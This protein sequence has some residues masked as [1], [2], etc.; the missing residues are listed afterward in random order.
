MAP[1]CAAGNVGTELSFILPESDVSN[2]PELFEQLEKSKEKLG[3]LGF[4][5]SVTTM[6]EVFMRYRGNISYIKMT[7]SCFVRDS[8][9]LNMTC[10]LIELAKA[11]T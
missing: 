9:G 10:C 6:E 8:V 1:I 4:G 2:F 7:C 5:A 11:M 3:V